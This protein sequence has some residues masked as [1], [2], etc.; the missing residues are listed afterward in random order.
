MTLLLKHINMKKLLTLLLLCTSCFAIGQTVPVTL[1][2]VNPQQMPTNTVYQD[3]ITKK[4]YVYNGTNFGWRQLTDSLQVKRMITAAGSGVVSFNGRTGAVT[5]SGSDVTSALGFSP[6]PVSG[7][8]NYIQNQHDTVQTGEFVLSGTS[9]IGNP[10]YG[11]RTQLGLNYIKLFDDNNQYFTFQG[12][13]INYY[14]LLT[15]QGWG[16]N[17]T[18]TSMVISGSKPTVF[19]T[20]VR[21]TLTPVDSTDVL[22][23]KDTSLVLNSALKMSD[24]TG[25]TPLVIT[26]QALA[27]SLPT[28]IKYP[29][30]LTFRPFGLTWDGSKTVYNYQMDEEVRNF[31]DRNVPYYC[32]PSKPNDTGDGL[33]WATAKKSLRAL[34]QTNAAAKV[35]YIK[36]GLWHRQE[37]GMY[38][39]I[40]INAAKDT[41]VVIGMGDCKITQYTLPSL[42][43]WSNVAGSVY[44]TVFDSITNVVDLKAIGADGLPTVYKHAHSLQG[45][46]DTA[47]MWYYDSGFLYTH[48][49]AGR[50]AP[51]DS[52]KLVNTTRTDVFRFTQP[53][54]RGMLYIGNVKFHGAGPKFQRTLTTR[55]SQWGI[56]L[57]QCEGAFA[58]FIYGGSGGNAYGFYT[59]GVGSIYTYRC[60]AYKNEGDGFHYENTNM[61]A[62]H[63]TN[64]LELSDVGFDNGNVNKEFS[65]SD[66]CNGSSAHEK[67]NILGIDGSYYNNRGPNI[68]HIR[69]NRIMYVGVN[70]FKSSSSQSG[71]PGRSSDFNSQDF[72][73]IYLYN[74]SSY[75]STYST[76]TDP[77]VP[78]T[79]AKGHVIIVSPSRLLSIQNN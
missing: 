56:R 66:A 52:L 65:L 26:Q 23:L 54:D 14:S 67:C 4:Y 46:T 27:Y 34:I 72:S 16:I 36:P 21:S 58:P 2:P 40:V 74:C 63:W 6:A 3:A 19:S 24:T 78:I 62:A 10:M 45:L 38:Q 17:P 64:V 32:D 60:Q 28:Q 39:S 68:S 22:R 79:Y 29:D 43:T 57:N 35:I 48:L 42:Y 50:T 33:S 55:V 25:L 18:D 44:R 47:A 11:Q 31:V 53:N 9:F 20:K 8:N 69:V 13:G 61:P 71:G 30:T 12:S 15:G 76:F 7:S 49:A 41:T 77:L 37:H 51:D 75:G 70:A 73:T 5:L 59:L 1:P